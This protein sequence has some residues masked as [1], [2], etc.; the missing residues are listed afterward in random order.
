LELLNIIGL[1][2]RGYSHQMLLRP[3]DEKMAEKLGLT[4][5]EYSCQQAKHRSPVEIFNSFAKSFSYASEKV[6]EAPEFHAFALMTI[7]NLVCA[8]LQI[9]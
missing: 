8:N 7:F 5:D 4:L 9:Q 6:R 1:S 2:D 3:D